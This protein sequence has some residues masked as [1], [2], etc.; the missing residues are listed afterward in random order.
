[1]AVV[2]CVS[3][4]GCYY[5]RLMTLRNQLDDYNSNFAIGVTPSRGYYVMFKHP[6]LYQEDIEKLAGIHPIVHGDDDP[7]TNQNVYYMVWH[8]AANVPDSVPITIQ[9]VKRDK[10]FKVGQ[11]TVPQKLTAVFPRDLVYQFMASSNKASINYFTKKA[12]FPLGGLDLQLLPKTSEIQR[13]FGSP[14]VRI[15]GRIKSEKYSFQIAGQGSPDRLPFIITLE[16]A[17]D[18]QNELRQ[19]FVKY[20]NYEL[21][22][23]LTKK[24][25]VL[26]YL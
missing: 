5:D 18:R 16:Y 4:V 14:E 20:Y 13:I 1:M 10:E 25:A 8:G 7:V 17:T 3:L 15:N 22:V 6:M 9:C 23:D 26:Q 24:E 11:V 2:A 21:R 19:L 12:T